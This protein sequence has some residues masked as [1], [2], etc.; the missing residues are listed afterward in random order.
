MKEIRKMTNED[1]GF[2]EIFGPVFGAREI[3]RKTG[4]RFYDDDKKEWYIEQDETGEA[5]AVVSVAGTVIKNVYAKDEAVLLKILKELYY[6]ITDSIVHSV[7]ADI[8]REVGYSVDEEERLKK[9]IKI[10][11]GNENGTIII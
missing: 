3:Q 8:Y 5:L 10:R 2:Y 9:F 11:G 1:S 7:Y 4:D 6:V